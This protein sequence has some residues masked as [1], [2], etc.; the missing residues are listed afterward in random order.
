M[1][2][3]KETQEAYFGQ[4]D[5]S[6]ENTGRVLP[7]LFNTE[8]VQ[9]ILDGR[10]TVTRR[11]V[12]KSQCMLADKKEPREL[13]RKYALF[14][15]MTDAELIASTYKQPYQRG[16][17]LYVRETWRV[18]AWDIHKQMIAFDYKDGTCGE[19][20]HIHD[21]QLFERLVD[22]SR[23]DARK[24]RCEYN[25]VDF[26]WEKGKSPCRWHPSIHMSKEAARIWL[27]VTDVWV[28]RLQDI[29]D[30]GAKA[31]GANWKNGKHVGFEEKL[32]RSAVERFAEIWN[33]TIKSAD[34]ILY[35][36]DANSFVW[37]IEFKRCEKPEDL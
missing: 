23:E 31:E 16:D 1:G 2:K 12:K 10:K 36:W 30:E 19:L 28:E 25:G 18:G 13:D 29:D 27:K 22:Q 4:T 35:G 37:V 5:S 33:G 24:A 15:G 11:L 21:R 9:A 26:V 6:E 20:V 3:W 14:D 7:I 17:I 34:Q 32:Q 8:M